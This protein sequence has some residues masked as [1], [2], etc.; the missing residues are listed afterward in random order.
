MAILS[1]Q[2]LTAS[3]G[4]NTVA[5]H[6]T[7]KH[8]QHDPAPKAVHARHRTT[9]TKPPRRAPNDPPLRH[10][11]HDCSYSYNYPD[12]S[13]PTPKTSKEKFEQGTARYIN[14]GS[15]HRSDE[16]AVS[17]PRRSATTTQPACKG[18][19]RPYSRQ[20]AH[21]TKATAASRVDQHA[22]TVLGPQ[23]ARCQRLDTVPRSTQHQKKQHAKS[24]QQ[25]TASGSESTPHPPPSPRRISTCSPL[26]PLST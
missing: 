17:S 13:N 7:R 20:C 22:S 26:V 14:I 4:G 18:A 1:P 19:Y 3:P 11:P 6:R 24:A 5:K 9:R 25:R 21:C 23:Q 15:R 12:A 2:Q 8:A 16:T 10:A